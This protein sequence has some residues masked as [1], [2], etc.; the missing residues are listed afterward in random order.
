MR[1]STREVAARK[2]ASRLLDVVFAEALLEDADAATRENRHDLAIAL[3]LADEL[4]SSENRHGF[5]S[6][7]AE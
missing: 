4:L 7:V 2:C 6:P 3:V 1:L 5:A